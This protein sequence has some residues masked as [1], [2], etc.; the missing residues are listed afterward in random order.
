MAIVKVLLKKEFGGKAGYIELPERE[1]DILF[2][3]GTEHLSVPQIRKKQT[4]DKNK[5]TDA[6]NYS[7]TERLE[8]RGYL[9][10]T[11]CNTN[12]TGTDL[13]RIIKY[14]VFETMEEIPVL[15]IPRKT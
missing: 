11:I 6:T 9:V 12:I 14:S 8:K 3:L 13:R 10:S 2:L 15:S 4:N 7:L 1:K 5:M